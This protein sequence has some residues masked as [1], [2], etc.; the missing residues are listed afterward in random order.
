MN[1]HEQ[2]HFHLELV[3]TNIGKNLLSQKQILSLRGDL[4]LYVHLEANRK[5]QK[6]VSFA[7][8]EKHGGLPAFHNY[9]M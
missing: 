3:L 6:H 5:R 9:N 4:T 1:A 2:S 7:K 8:I